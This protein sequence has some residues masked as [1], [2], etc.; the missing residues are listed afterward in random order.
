MRSSYR[1]MKGSRNLE[2]RISSFPQKVHSVNSL[3]SNFAFT[4]PDPLHSNSSPD[5]AGRHLGPF[6]KGVQTPAMKKAHWVLRK[7]PM[8][9]LPRPE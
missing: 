3:Y 6:A 4:E 5:L 9:V 1:N 8:D 2:S 7:W